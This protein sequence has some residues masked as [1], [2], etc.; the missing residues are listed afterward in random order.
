M[1]ANLRILVVEDNPADADLI[2]ALLAETGPVRFQI[3][4][5][6]RL[7]EALARLERRGIDLVLL[8]LGLPDSQGLATLHQLK[9]A[10]PEIPVIVLTGT[11]DSE[12]GSAAVRDGAQDYLF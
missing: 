4:S 11:D 9:K 6:A 2:H 12:L 1:S 7:S 10:V 3:E 8:D 5:V